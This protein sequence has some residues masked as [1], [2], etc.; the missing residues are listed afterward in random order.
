MIFTNSLMDLHS[1]GRKFTW[2]NQRSDNP[3]HIKL[4]RVLVNDS[5]L[6]EFPDSFYSLQISSCSDHCPIIVHSGMTNQVRHRFHFKNYWTSID[7]FWNILLKAF[8]ELVTGNPFPHL[9]NS[10]R[11]LKASIK[12]ESWSSY[13]SVSRHMDAL[14][15]NQMYLLE[16]LHA[17][18]YNTV[19]NLS[20]KDV[21]ARIAVFSEMH[22]SWIIQRAKVK[23]LKQGEN[24]LKFLYGKIR[25]RRG[26]SNSVV[27]L[28]ASASL[29]SRSEVVST[30]TQ[31]FWELYNP[32]HRI[33]DNLGMFPVGSIL[34]DFV[35]N[36][37]CS[38]V[39]DNDIKAV[40]FMGSSSA[41]PRAIK[42]FFSKGYMPN[43]V[44]HTALAIIPKH[45][46]VVN[47]SDYIPIALCNV[48]YKITTKVIACRLKP[49][50]P[51]IIENNLVSFLKSRISTDNILLASDILATANRKGGAHMFCA[52]LD[53]K[54]AFDSVNREFIFARLIQKGFPSTFVN[55]IKMCISDVKFSIVLNGALEGFFPST[56]WLRQGCPLSPYL[57]FLVMDAFLNILKERGFIGIYADNFNLT[58]LLYAD[59]VLVF[60][61]ASSHNCHKLASILRD[62]GNSTGLYVNFDKSAI[63]FPKHQ[64]NQHDICQILSIHNIT[65][66]ITYLGIPLSFH[67]LK[68]EDFLPFMDCINNKMNGWKAN[69]LSFAGRLQYLK[70]TIQNTISYWIRGSIL[71]KSVCKYFKKVS[72][73]FLFFCDSSQ[74]KKL[75]MISWDTICRPKHKGGLGVH[76]INAIQYAYNCSV[77]HRLYNND[78]PLSIWLKRKYSSP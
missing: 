75:H 7:G 1:V 69:L 77:I 16:R 9:C 76:S 56:A 4:D 34:T 51:L 3:I 6:K 31:H 19:F 58:H 48:G 36:D 47:I 11:S 41:S 42:S 29:P 38:F 30:I 55:W 67:R 40:V 22:A 26:N 24:D 72:S 39:N 59:D 13:N 17:D 64:R 28:L 32:P 21:N 61:E 63:M 49:V 27:N 45:K 8:S 5:W 44:K 62:F 66:K 35:A 60:G 50:M 71:P 57:F 33:I 65:T 53:I 10:L 68:V 74:S 18:P 70:F 37:L 78:S 46:N 43:G 12:S 52:K 14:Q 23:W 15:K 20:L 54:K 2:Y 73:R 25:C